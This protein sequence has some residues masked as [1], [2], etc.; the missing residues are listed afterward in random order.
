MRLTDSLGSAFE[1]LRAHKLRSVLTM[2]GIVIGVAAVIATVSIGGG[3][4]EDVVGRIKSL[5]ANLIIVLPGNI[6][7]GG[8][9]LG[10]GQSATLNDDDARAIEKEI[11]AVQVAAPTVRG[12][13]QVVFG[14]TNWGTSVFGVENNFFEAREWDVSSGRLFNG[15]ENQRG[16]QVAL[17][18]LTVKNQLFGED[19]PIGQTIRVKNVPFEVI[20]VMARKG[21]SAQG[22]DQDDSVFLPLQSA[23]QRVIGAS[24]AKTRTVG[25]MLIKVREGEDMAEAEAEIKSLLRQRHRLRE[26]DDDDF[27]LRNLTD[28]LSTVE[29][30]ARVLSIGLSAVAAV[31]LLVG[32]IGIMNIMLVSVTERTRE[33]GVRMAVGARPRDVMGQFLIEATTLALIGGVAG[34]LLGG[35]LSQLVSHLAGWPLYVDVSAIVMA[36]VVSGLIGILSGFYPA[37]RASRLDPVEALRSA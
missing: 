25:S 2:L 14:G 36:V 10:T 11:A 4:R 16:G 1:A 30:S 35:A 34:I 22:Q 27:T 9:R 29:A 13:A 12:G 3:A 37:W 23:R 8:V 32:G 26:G 7:S 20:G 31:S 24:R 18:G 19:D 5:G 15:E 21:Q 28:I 6:T 33:I 17:L